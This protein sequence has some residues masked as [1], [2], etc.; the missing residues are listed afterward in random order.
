V[1]LTDRIAGVGYSKD[2]SGGPHA[3]G[4]RI[5][6]GRDY[7]TW[8][9][10]PAALALAGFL[11]CHLIGAPQAMAVFAAIDA[12]TWGQALAAIVP[13]DDG[14]EF[15][16]IAAATSAAVLILAGMLLVELHL[17][18]AF[19]WVFIGVGAVSLSIQM[20]TWYARTASLRTRPVRPQ[21]V[22]SIID[23]KIIL[24]DR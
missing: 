1:T 5:P 16:T 6:S 2:K 20:L 3:R 10:I 24:E 11:I 7:R 14:I 17:T 19:L 13:S 22:P 23:G 18:G 15:A 21:R 12:L 8:A 9:I 4:N